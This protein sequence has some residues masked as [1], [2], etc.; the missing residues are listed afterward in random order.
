MSFIK[1]ISQD[2]AD[3]LLEDIYNEISGKRGKLSNIMK[4]QS[5]APKAMRAHLDLYISLLFSKSKLKRDEREAIATRVSFLNKCE[6]CISH[7]AEALNFYWKD[8]EKTESFYKEPEKADISE[9]LKA[10]VRYA[11][12]VTKNPSKTNESDIEDLREHGLEDR[13]ILILNMI[14]AY[15]N[16]VNRI[17]MGL[18][19]E[20][21]KEEIEGYNY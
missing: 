3:G 9:R 14:I 6:Y 20:F 2:K 17:A 13:D 12:K 7:H 19:V 5:L 10:F 1:E 15:F 8:K 11:D 21:S 18:G 16:F 4:V